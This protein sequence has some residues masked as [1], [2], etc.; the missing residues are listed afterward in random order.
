M[1]KQAQRL[2]IGDIA[3]RTGLSVSAIRFYES[4]GLVRPTRN[5]GGQRR[6]LRSD[7]RR[8]SF[9]RIA[10][11]LGFPLDDIR[12]Q[13]ETLPNERTP[14]RQDWA[15]IS[16]GFR[17]ELQARIDLMTRMRDRLDGCIGCGCLS[18]SNCR[19]YNPDDRA[20]RLGPGPR[21]LLGDE[22]SDASAASPDPHAAPARG[23]RRARKA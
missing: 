12:A 8:L 13:L 18:L 1:A 20:Q 16:R 22:P 9:I 3:E 10:Q 2:S 4:Q 21:Y 19:L 11:Q 7:L 5:S 6:F 17:D 14:T 15:R 23:R